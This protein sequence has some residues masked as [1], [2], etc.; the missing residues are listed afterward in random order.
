MNTHLQRD[1]SQRDA[2][3]PV[4]RKQVFGGVQDLLERFGALLGLDCGAS[5]RG[6]TFRHGGK[7]YLLHSRMCR[8][9]SQNQKQPTMPAR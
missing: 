5:V 1:V 8:A 7:E 6:G 3:Q 2:I 9:R 4:F